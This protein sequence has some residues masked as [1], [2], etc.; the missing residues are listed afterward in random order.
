MYGSEVVYFRSSSSKMKVRKQ[1][2]TIGCRTV[3]S[4]SIWGKKT[5]SLESA[6]QQEAEAE[7]RGNSL[8]KHCNVSALFSLLVLQ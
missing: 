1:I 2:P 3:W 5:V 7:L 6:R 4:P 8:D